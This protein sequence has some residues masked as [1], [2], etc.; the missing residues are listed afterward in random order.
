MLKN[1]VFKN[2]VLFLFLG[3]LLINSIT[4]FLV[5]RL[6]TSKIIVLH[7][8][9][10]VGA[11]LFGKASELLRLPLTGYFILV[12]NTILFFVLRKRQGFLAEAGMWVAFV[13]C[14]IL[15]LFYFNIRL[16]N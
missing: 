14:L 5:R 10:I 7:Y 1:W 12:L 11:D 2:R 13:I 4:L 6:E 3:A 15:H 8:N 9:V 16:I